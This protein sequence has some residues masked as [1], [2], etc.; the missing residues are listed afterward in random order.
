MKKSKFDLSN[1]FK[2]TFSLGELIPF[3][4]LDCIPGD[5]IKLT[6]QSLIRLQPLLAPIM[7]RVDLYTRYY[8][9]PYRLL[10]EPF[11]EVITKPDDPRTLPVMSDFDKSYV[12][13]RFNLF[14]RFGIQGKLSD[15][16][17]KNLSAFPFLAYKL[18]VNYYFRDPL[19][20]SKY[21]D[22]FTP[23]ELI[24][25]YKKN[26][27][28]LIEVDR[29][30]W[31]RDYFTSC[32]PTT[33]YGT[34]VDLDLDGNQVIKV[35]EMR[36]ADAL[37]RFKE[38]LLLGGTRFKDFVKTF[39][40]TDIADQSLSRP[41]LLGGQKIHLN[42][43]DVDQLVAT[44]T[45]PLGNL[46]GKS[47][48]LLDHNGYSFNCHEHGIILGLAW[49]SP[50]QCYMAGI[51]RSFMKRD[52]Y[53]FAIPNF[54]NL[55]LQETYD[56]ELDPSVTSM[57]VFGYNDR[58]SEYK[59]SY[60]V[61]TGGFA[62]SL[63]FWHF[64]RDLKRQTL[65]NAFVTSHPTSNPF[66]VRDIVSYID[67]LT[68]CICYEEDTHLLYFYA[69]RK[70]FD[71][72]NP[73]SRFK[74]NYKT[75]L[76]D[77]PLDNIVVGWNDILKLSPSYCKEN[78]VDQIATILVEYRDGKPLKGEYVLAKGNV[79]IGV[80]NVDYTAGVLTIRT[81]PSH[82]DIADKDILAIIKTDTENFISPEKYCVDAHRV[83]DQ[84]L[85]V[86]NNKISALRPLPYI[87]DT[88]SMV[89]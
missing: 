15:L 36:W 25:Y 28:E 41:L 72:D 77:N 63:Y 29:V 61:V 64:A 53:D 26:P 48:S 71:R 66:A 23:Q 11:T 58:Y 78:S 9:I 83:D 33:Q 84:I 20:N 57:S 8:F 31:Q 6:N 47:V 74:D 51:P 75:H 5:S 79:Y 30:L 44:Q 4:F 69:N 54:A 37:Q 2:T 49:A 10:F 85:A 60:D 59:H 40:H 19:L 1:E 34:E 39:Y 67:P 3:H 21:N 76:T 88:S 17:L 27:D 46:G 81:D 22:N 87:S 13:S 16:A 38:K 65:S 82:T 42:V 12:N 62:N 7:N 80:P 43:S 86:F 35:S 18:V 70:A 89:Y 56:L 32:K 24:D 73:N 55:G 45:D 68:C 14:D 52:F 50:K